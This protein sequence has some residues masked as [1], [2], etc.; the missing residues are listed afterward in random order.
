MAQKNNPGTFGTSTREN[1][2]V[3]LYQNKEAGER[4]PV[5]LLDLYFSKFP[6]LSNDLDFFYLRPLQT[7]PHDKA[8][9]WFTAVAIG[10]NTLAKFVENMCSD[11]EI[12]KKTNHSLRATGAS[13]MFT[14]GVPEKIIKNITGHKS[15]KALEV[16]ER[17]ST[18]QLEAVS[19]LQI[20]LFLLKYAKY[21]L[22]WSKWLRNM[23]L[24]RKKGSWNVWS[25]VF[26]FKQLFY[27]VFSSNKGCEHP[28]R[29]Q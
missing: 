3:T 15:S 28:E 20:H 9:P 22:K 25:H 29:E 11:A 19:Q 27:T 21:L 10:R 1:K 16:Y 7:K 13:T 24:L 4:C 2:V 18:E 14:A 5:Y 26:L 23:K 8:K 12:A 17:P 6:S